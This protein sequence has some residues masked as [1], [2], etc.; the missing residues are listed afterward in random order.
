VQAQDGTGRWAYLAGGA[1]IS[2]PAVDDEGTVYVGVS[3]ATTRGRLL[4]VKRD[5]SAKWRQYPADGIPLSHAVDAAP[6][7]GPNNMLY[8]GTWGGILYAYTRDGEF[9]WQYTVGGGSPYID[10]SA[11]VTAD[12]VIYFGTGD[13]GPDSYSGALVALTPGGVTLWQ[14]KRVDAPVDSSPAIGPDGTIYFADSGGVVYALNREDGSEKWRFD[15][16]TDT[17]S[18]TPIQSS[19]V[20]DRQGSVYIGAGFNS[21]Y[22]LTPDGKRKWRFDTGDY[23][24]ATPALGADGTLYIGSLDGYLYALDS[25]DGSL[26]WRFNAGAPIFSSAVVRADGTVIFGC[27]SDPAD[28]AGRGSVFAVTPGEHGAVQLW[29]YRTN[30]HVGSSPVIDKDGFI[31]VGSDDKKLHAIAG[32][33][34]PMSTFSAWPS[35]RHDPLNSGRAAP[36]LAGGRII[37]LST[38]SRVGADSLL[39]AGFGISGNTAKSYLVRGVG[40]GLTPFGIT[41]PLPDPTIA[42]QAQGASAPLAENNDWGDPTRFPSPG[43]AAGIVGAFALP[44]QSTDAA[45]VPLLA[46]GV[47]TASVGARDGRSGTALVEIYDVRPDATDA[48]LTNVSTLARLSANSELIPALVVGGDAPIR[49]LIRAVGPTLRSFGRTD[50]LQRP[51]IDVLAQDTHAVL[52]SNSGWTAGGITGDLN[53]AGALVGAFPLPAGSTDAALITTLAPGAYSIQVTGINGSLGEALV[54]VYLLP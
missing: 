12:G 6:A 7:L 14:P 31:Y 44:E 15:V 29:R 10:S 16:S 11:A 52:A 33:G 20:V 25:R 49:V 43:D 37:N 46:P 18:I 4:A 47:Y 19:P 13:L 26:K 35:F 54:E 21:V 50:V 40:P 48:T 9:R 45:T 3:P 2:S 41:E 28:P 8:V 36:R 17:G 30:D 1:V 27:D 39:I 38:R 32:N 22:A 53:G 34:S 51:R 42:V 5:G 24:S 23:V